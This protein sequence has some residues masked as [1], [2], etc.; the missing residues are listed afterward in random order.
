MND[1]KDYIY[2]CIGDS[3][4]FTGYH[5]HDWI[6]DADCGRSSGIYFM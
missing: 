2:N 1:I 4:K 6:L 5:I 3:C